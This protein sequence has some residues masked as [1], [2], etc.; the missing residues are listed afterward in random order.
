MLNCGPESK[1]RVQSKV[2]SSL[3]EKANDLLD[4][5]QVNRCIP[6]LHTPLLVEIMIR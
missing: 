1:V 6:E 4:Y 5:D 3:W 2:L